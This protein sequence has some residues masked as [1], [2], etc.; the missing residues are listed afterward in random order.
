MLAAV[1][2]VD[3]LQRSFILVADSEHF[4]ELPQRL[5]ATAKPSAS[6]D[7]TGGNRTKAR[8]AHVRQT[9]RRLGQAQLPMEERALLVRP[10]V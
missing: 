5:R 7:L 6:S 9:E 3:G 1:P 8:S 2:P 4:E 10:N